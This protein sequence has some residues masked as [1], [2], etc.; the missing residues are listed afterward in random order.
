M[1]MSDAFHSKFFKAADLNGGALV[2]T[3]GTVAFESMN[4]GEQKPVARFSDDDRGLVL[5]KTNFGALAQLAKSD[6]TANWRGMRV[7]LYAATAEFSGR[8][9]PAVRIRSPHG[10]APKQSQR[11]EM[12][13]QIPF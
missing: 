2:R 1:R 5:N 7:Q 12:D 9:V 11:E 3:V 8:T 13:D 4:D 10:A 6:D